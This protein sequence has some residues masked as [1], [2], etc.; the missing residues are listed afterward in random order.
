MV[1]P[2]RRERQHAR[3]T[4]R[5][6]VSTLIPIFRQTVPET[7]T[8]LPPGWAVSLGVVGRLHGAADVGNEHVP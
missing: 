3:T 1:C 8:A 2:L 5:L 4:R 6:F 7:D